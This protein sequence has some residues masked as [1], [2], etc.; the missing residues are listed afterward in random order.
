MEFSTDLI[1]G[2]MCPRLY[3]P[4]HPDCR[5]ITTGASYIDSPV[6]SMVDGPLGP[7]PALTAGCL[8]G[9]VASVCCRASLQQRVTL[10]F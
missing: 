1:I 9:L 7:T 10:V 5:P 2:S 8:A 3:G 6:E 4:F